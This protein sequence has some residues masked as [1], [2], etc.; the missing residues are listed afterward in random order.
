MQVTAFHK[1]LLSVP[2]QEA[3]NH[4]YEC[5]RSDDG[6]EAAFQLLEDLHGPKW[7]VRGDKF[8][9]FLLETIRLLKAKV[10]A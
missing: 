2:E 6:G 3:A 9:E 8:G 7:S 10:A 1:W 5:L 4:L